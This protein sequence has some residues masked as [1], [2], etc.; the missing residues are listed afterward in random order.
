MPK[1]TKR[2]KK[3]VK[4]SSIGVD[5]EYRN[6]GIGTLMLNEMKKR[7][8]FSEIDYVTLETDAK[9]NDTVNDFYRKN[10]F[11]LSYVLVTPE[12]RQMNVYHLHGS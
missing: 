11:K 9:G 2:D 4:I 12:G 6:H 3:S 1:R 7:V 10:G 5:P 8:D